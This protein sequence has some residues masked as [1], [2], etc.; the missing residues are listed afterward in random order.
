MAGLISF[1][2]EKERNWQ[3]ANWAFWSLLRRVRPF[4]DPGSRIRS[5]ISHIETTKIEYLP[6]D[7][8]PE[9]EIRMFERAVVGVR[10]SLRSQGVDV[11]AS[12]EFFPSY[13]EHLDQL[14]ALLRSEIELREHAGD[15][16]SP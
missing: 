4:L 12:P 6:L 5:R 2:E 16:F 13:M 7:G 1:G 9:N 11:F 15:D 14:V 10:D 3:A 8:L